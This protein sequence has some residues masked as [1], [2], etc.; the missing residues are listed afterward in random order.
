V[1]VVAAVATKV[2]AA[3]VVALIRVEK[4]QIQLHRIK[5]QAVTRVA[6]RVAARVADHLQP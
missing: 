3:A 6:A 1:A 5:A 2:V 4:T